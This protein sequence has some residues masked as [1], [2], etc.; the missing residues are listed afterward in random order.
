MLCKPMMLE[1][2]INN[3]RSLNDLQKDFNSL[4]PYLKVEFYDI[5]NLT[6]KSSSKSKLLNNSLAVAKSRRSTNEGTFTFNGNMS[7][8]LFERELWDKFGLW[9]Q[10]YRMSGKVWIETSLTE[11]WT[12]D[13]QN[14]E[15]FE[16]SEKTA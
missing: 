8:A 12:L 6:Q 14:N 11:S 13:R 2:E 16:M 1:I 15:G 4:F 9:A 7:V 10:V 3:S 5:P